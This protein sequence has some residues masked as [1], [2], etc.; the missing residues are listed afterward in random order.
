MNNFLLSFSIFLDL[1]VIGAVTW[2]LYHLNRQYNTKIK[3]K[4]HTAFDVFKDMLRASTLQDITSG[5]YD[6]VLIGPVGEFSEYETEFVKGVSPI[7]SDYKPEHK[8][9]L[10]HPSYGKERNLSTSRTGA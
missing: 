10:S 8:N 1:I 6:E 4:D 7:N 5:S 9:M 2:F 3:T